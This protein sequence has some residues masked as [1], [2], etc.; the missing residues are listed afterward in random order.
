MPGVAGGASWSGGA[1]DP[2]T[3]IYYV[4][5]VRLPF[6]LKLFK[7]PAMASGDRYAGRYIYLSGPR[8]L[9]LFKPPWGSLVAIDMTTA[10]ISGGLRR[11]WQHSPATTTET[12]NHGAARLPSALRLVTNSLLL[13]VQ[14]GYQ[15]NERRLE[16]ARRRIS[17]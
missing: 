4:T 17:I 5:T 6:V 15:N 13:T 2:E 14:T 1:W 8:S 7:P 3:G 16:R 11:H 9:P 12:K 10:S